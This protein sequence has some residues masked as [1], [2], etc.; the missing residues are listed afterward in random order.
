MYPKLLQPN[1]TESIVFSTNEVVR[2]P[3]VHLTFEKWS[4]IYPDDTYGNKTVLNFNDE[5]VFA[6]LAILRIFQKDGWNGVWVDTYG[7]KYRNS[8]WGNAPIA[9]LPE[10]KQLLL[11]K[12]YK[13]AEINSGCFDVFC[14]NEDRV[15]FAEAKRQKKDKI[16]ANQI[17]WLE[18]AFE[19]GLKEDSFL[20]VEWDLA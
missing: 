16:R 12:I 2:I 1:N 17:K 13:I 6:E 19:N 5:P 4:G 11:N 14:W 3:K 9:E 8:Y 7:R 18:A 10:E 20:I 15:I